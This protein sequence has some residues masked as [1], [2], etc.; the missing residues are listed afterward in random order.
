LRYS[1]LI[2]SKKGIRILTGSEILVILAF[3][4]LLFDWLPVRGEG[5]KLS[6][7]VTFMT[8]LYKQKTG[9]KVTRRNMDFYG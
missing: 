4:G 6:V 7:Y 3:I 8:S 2:S 9:D 5:L 1:C